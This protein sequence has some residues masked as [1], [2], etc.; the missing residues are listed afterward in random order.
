VPQKQVDI[1]KDYL[2]LCPPKNSSS[3]QA[4]TNSSHHKEQNSSSSMQ[5]LS[6]F[7]YA[8]P[9]TRNEAQTPRHQILS[10]LSFQNAASKPIQAYPGSHMQSC[11]FV[12]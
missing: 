3:L 7:C 9:S 10:L 4:Y 8:Q 1:I 11:K 2:Q 12:T 5:D 6:F